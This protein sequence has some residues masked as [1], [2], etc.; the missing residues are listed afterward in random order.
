VQHVRCRE[1][2]TAGHDG[3]AGLE[4]GRNPPLLREAIAAETIET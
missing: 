2:S 4:L 1:L 3:R